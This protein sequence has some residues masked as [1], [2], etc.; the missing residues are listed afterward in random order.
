MAEQDIIDPEIVQTLGDHFGQPLMAIEEVSGGL[1]NDVARFR[2]G[3]VL[4]YFKKF[5]DTAKEA[6]FPP[7]PTT[8][9]DRWRVAL[10]CHHHALNGAGEKLA[11]PELVF[12]DTTKTYLI[13]GA[14][15]GQDLFYILKDVTQ[16]DLALEIGDQA[17]AWLRT[18]HTVAMEGLAMVEKA[19][20]P[21]KLYK[22]NLQYE[23]LLPLLSEQDV[24]KA[25]SFIGTI[26]QDSSCV[27]HGDINS[28]N[29]L[30]DPK[31]G[32]SIIDFEQ[33]QVGDPYYDLAYLCSEYVIAAIV[34]HYDLDAVIARQWAAYHDQA[35]QDVPQ[36]QGAVRFQIHLGFQCLYRLVGPSRHVWTG[37][38]TLDQCDA[39]RKWATQHIEHWLKAINA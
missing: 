8:A 17:C 12:E 21:H 2:C 5:N 37:H 25:K 4:Y 35:L 24:P 15:S 30:Y 16:F 39:L 27:L 14:V 38:L 29:I 23:A 18:F 9:F 13:M 6:A 22:I 7:L 1:F 34:A 26:Q 33:G 36:G 20:Q 31:A 10:A 32:V 11:V 28:R 19:S 3:G